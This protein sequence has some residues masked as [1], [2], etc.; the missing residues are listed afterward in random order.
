MASEPPYV[1]YAD[2]SAQDVNVFYET[3]VELIRSPLVI[4]LALADR[5]VSSLK[6]IR[7]QS[8]PAIWLAEQLSVTRK[9][10]SEL[11]VVSLEADDRRDAAV[12]VNAVVDAYVKAFSLARR[13]EIGRQLEA[14]EAQRPRAIERLAN[15]HR[16]YQQAAAKLLAE[17]A[18]PG[19]ESINAPPADTQEATAPEVGHGIEL[20]DGELR[21]QIAAQFIELKASEARLD[22][23]NE[24][25][26]VEAG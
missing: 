26:A 21:R 11:L 25:E 2:S 8:K 6:L 3:Q 9:G 12:I 23:F 20:T 1:L 24:A 18:T 15:L 5:S 16:E 14:V 10:E 22:D 7:N 4:D 19:A 13:R 17:F